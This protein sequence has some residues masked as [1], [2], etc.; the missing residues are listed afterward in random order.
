MD[1][2]WGLTHDRLRRAFVLVDPLHG[3]KSSDEMLLQSLRENAISHQ[4]ILSKV[5]RILFTGTKSLSEA[6][7]QSNIAQ[8]R[9]ICEGVRAKIQ[10]GKSDGPEALGE[11]I[12]CSAD[13]KLDKERKLGLD[14]VRWA[15]LT[16]AGL[17]NEKRK[18]SPLEFVGEDEIRFP[19]IK[20]L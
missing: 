11:I 1:K 18:L 10:P 5:D 15:V 20:R 6:Q 9:E 13:T 19:S 2:S 3:L 14:Q 8:L 16:A 4:V 17:G 7:L 12:G